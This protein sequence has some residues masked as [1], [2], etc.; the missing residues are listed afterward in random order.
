M[1][2]TLFSLFVFCIICSSLLII[3]FRPA[4]EE[5]R[6][7]T[8]SKPLP[9][10]PNYSSEIDHFASR[11]RAIALAMIDK[12]G[13][14]PD[15]KFAFVPR[16]PDQFDW[17]KS[18]L[19]LMSTQSIKTRNAVRCKVPLFVD[20]NMESSGGD[21]FKAIYVQGTLSL[22]SNSRILEWA[23]AD[24]DVVFGASCNAPRRMSSTV[25][26]NLDDGCSFERI[27]API[28]RFGARLPIE[29]R[30]GDADLVEETFASVPQAIRRTDSLYMIKG[31][32]DLPAGKTYRGSLVVTG[33][34]S[35]GAGTRIIGDVKARMGI[36]VGAGAVIGGSLI[37]E[38]KIQILE[39][40][41][42]KGPVISETVI[43]I[44]ACSRIGI[45]EIPTTL[46]AKNI[47]AESGVVAHGTVWATELGVVWSI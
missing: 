11:F 2:S 45:P 17:T 46:S 40:A 9:V 38:K 12:N 24:A 35:I 15:Q 25:A 30:N 5:W 43:L 34:L 8:D 18:P 27:S 33:Y 32:C 47:I 31:D 41:C 39:Q 7:P 44:G 16:D 21:S 1:T 36:V 37:C 4:W 3:A 20:G 14:A 42:I 28:V 22:G 13:R 6:R 29:P 23:H 19:P 26:V 10:S